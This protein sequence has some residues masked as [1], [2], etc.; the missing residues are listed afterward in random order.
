MKSE[1]VFAHASEGVMCFEKA[2]LTLK[3]SHLYCLVGTFLW[4]RLTPEQRKAVFEKYYQHQWNDP[5]DRTNKKAHDLKAWAD[6]FDATRPDLP[7]QMPLYIGATVSKKVPISQL[8]TAENDELF[9][10]ILRAR[11]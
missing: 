2:T 3:D 8:Y 11:E 9:Q 7:M 6:L 10:L 5:E 1:I 4:M